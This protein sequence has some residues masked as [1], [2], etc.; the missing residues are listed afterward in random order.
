MAVILEKFG[1]RVPYPENWVVEEGQDP[2]WPDSVSIQSPG[3]AFW[4]LSVHDASADT[5]EIAGVVLNAI[6]EEYDEVEAEAVHEVLAETDLYGFDLNF[7]CMRLVVQARLRTFSL[8]GRKFLVLCQGED[9]E[10][11]RMSAV[12]EAMTRSVLDPHLA[13]R[14]QDSPH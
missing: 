7:C 11:D 3:N 12:F 9:R 4:S 14:V 10:F 8:A 1:V 2:H 6:R 5:N 13:D